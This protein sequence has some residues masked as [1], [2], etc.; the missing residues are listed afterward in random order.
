MNTK[1]EDSLYNQLESATH[2]SEKKQKVPFC[3]VVS[4]PHGFE[5]VSPAHPKM[6]YNLDCLAT[7]KET[8]RK[9]V[10]VEDCGHAEVDLHVLK[11][12][13]CIPFLINI[14]VKPK[15]KREKCFT[16]PHAKE[17]SLC[18]EGSV[19]VDHVLKCSVGSL[20]DVHIDCQYVTVCDLHLSPAHE[21]AC[22]FVKITG[23]FQF[24][25]M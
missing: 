17:I 20:P 23:E 7:I 2:C 8:C 19:C 21:G 12:K 9:T 24:Y 25:S 3:C 16:E 5:L 10:Q 22:Q 11:V 14:E 1:R 4:I 13:G 6:A 18:C 15:G